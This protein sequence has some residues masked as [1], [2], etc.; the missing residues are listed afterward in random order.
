MSAGVQKSTGPSSSA[1]DPLLDPEIYS[2]LGTLAKYGVPAVIIG[3]EWHFKPAGVME[4]EK[5]FAEKRDKMNA[6]SV[7]SFIPGTI[8]RESF[9]ELSAVPI[10]ASRVPSMCQYLPTVAAM[11]G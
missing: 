2:G 6:V 8:F 1:T 7:F 4:V 3:S 5:R 9:R 10:K 11:T